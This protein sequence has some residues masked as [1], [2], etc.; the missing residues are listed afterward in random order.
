MK[1]KLALL[2]ALAMLLSLTACGKGEQPIRPD[3]NVSTHSD[4]KR[5]TGDTSAATDAPEP[6][7][8]PLLQSRRISLSSSAFLT[9]PGE[10]E[11]SL[12]EESAIE[13]VNNTVLVYANPG[14]EES[15]VTDFVQDKGAEVVGSLSDLD[16]YQIR[17]PDNKTLDQIEDLTRE[18]EEEPWVDEAVP[19]YVYPIPEEPEE[20][21]STEGTEIPEG[22]DL[23]DPDIPNFPGY[24]ERLPIGVVDIASDGSQ[25]DDIQVLPDSQTFACS[26]G[27]A[28]TVSQLMFDISTLVTQ[29]SVKVIQINANA[30]D[31]LCVLAASDGNPIAQ[32]VIEVQAKAAA[33]A[34]NRLL[35]MGYDFVICISAGNQNNEVFYKD[36]AD[37]IGGALGNAFGYAMEQLPDG[38]PCQG[39]DALY[40]HYLSYITDPRIRDRIIVVGAVTSDQEGGYC[41]V[42][43]SNTGSRVDIMAPGSC[44]SGAVQVAARA[45]AQVYAYNQ[46]LTGI[47]IKSLLCD[48]ASYTIPFSGVPAGV[49]DLVPAI[50]A[51]IPQSISIATAL[52]FFYMNY[53]E[54]KALP[55]DEFEFYDED[56]LFCVGTYGDAKVEFTFFGKD[57]TSPY[58]VWVT[59]NALLGYESALNLPIAPG[60]TTGSTYDEIN[61]L[62]G[63]SELVKDDII[64]WGNVTAAYYYADDTLFV[65]LD[66]LGGF[67]G[68]A[69]M[70]SADM[71][72]IE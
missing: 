42:D 23:S 4:E 40:N 35:D 32:R 16:I 60:V 17:F 3:R 59:D 72:V 57:S 10:D 14:T 25:T 5:D 64:P 61:S 7:T 21:E 43:S 41:P 39:A 63:L 8:R 67:S 31:I 70:F 44:T 12:D 6:E 68:D 50:Q 33:A 49:L 36:A 52:D 20:P 18:L 37:Q 28:A 53:D 46:D 54:I 30:N 55:W 65:T 56:V 2:C 15:A 51:A 11:V 62:V 48:T 34:L 45:A 9:T 27:G 71:Q 26:L 38:T 29:Y 22:F 69:V 1:R 13:Y 24:V 58:R 19:D 47:E 66:F